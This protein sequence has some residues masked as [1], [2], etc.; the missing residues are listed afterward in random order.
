VA[1]YRRAVAVVVA[2]AAV[3]G[4][5][6][7]GDKAGG[8]RGPQ[9]TV[10]T[11]A[12]T[13]GGT[14]I[15][16]FIDEI[17]RASHGSVRIVS[18]ALP[19]TASGDGEV[20]VIDEVLSGRAD[21][22]VAAAQVLRR[23]GVRSL[24]P[25]LAPLEI[26]SLTAEQK[27]LNGERTAEFLADL[28]RIGLDGI[29]V[30]PG[31]LVRPAGITRELRGPDDYPNAR[32]AAP[33]SEPTTGRLTA[34]GAT[35]VP[36]NLNTATIPA[37]GLLAPASTVANNFYDGQ[38]TTITANVVVGTQPLVVFG[39]TANRVP[40]IVR[41]ATTAT[42]AASVEALRREENA[43]VA[44]L[45]RRGRVVFVTASDPD[46]VALRRALAEVLPTAGTQRPDE[47][48][49]QADK[50]HSADVLTCAGVDGGTAI[51]FVDGIYEVPTSSG[52]IQ[53]TFD[54]GTYKGQ[55]VGGS[56][57]VHG[58]LLT[59]TYRAGSQAAYYRWI[60]Y[61]DELTLYPVP[62][63]NSPEEF[64]SKPW[65]RTGDVPV[66]SRTPVDGRY[67]TSAGSGQYRWTLDRGQ[68]T[69]ARDNVG[70]WAAG[71]YT[72][73]GDI[74]ALT[75]NRIGGEE[76]AAGQIKPGDV[77]SYRWNLY[78]G[79]LHLRPLQGANSPMSLCANPWRRT[80]DAP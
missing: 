13:V 30:L 34:M 14:P 20:A 51:T 9:P 64:R 7:S 44:A 19:P 36:H 43:A 56:Y 12:Y 59:M 80:G 45:C 60:L 74:I 2:T 62:G 61:H 54:R 66:A 72:L 46:V 11:L 18:R 67:E 49:R 21:L 25:L 1:N 65:H 79:R 48:N 58:N 6:V 31:P 68:F 39:A 26:D 23:V 3:A 71:S 63:K 73:T 10:L 17:G 77:V 37:D 47:G 29:G 55:R 40:T 76:R 28:A 8:R 69:Q 53:L 78:R 42:V 50:A 24:D 41:T 15:R 75:Y 35:I 32:I 27:A 22:G 4:C 38:V 57:S 70:T 52:P 16:L 33:P 5:G